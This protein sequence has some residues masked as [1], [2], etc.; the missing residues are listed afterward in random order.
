M[1]A[2][3]PPPAIYDILNSPGTAAEI[4]TFLRVVRRHAP[5][6]LEPGALWLEPACGT[7]R[8]LRALARRG[9]RTAGFDT[10]PCMLAY[11]AG[12]RELREAVLFRADMGDFAGPAAAAGLLDGSAAAALNPV[13]SLRHLD[14][15]RAVLD[16]LEHMAGLLEPGGAYLVGISLT[17][18][19]RLE[20]EED[21]WEG[22]RSRCRVSQLVNYLPPEPGTSRARTETVISHLTVTRPRGAEH[23]DHTYGLRTYDEDQW[24][25]LVSRSPLR[26]AGSYDA[27][28]RP[29]GGRTLPYQLEVLAR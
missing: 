22:A 21:L 5:G 20:P 11:A 7:G 13:N 24:N 12:R 26:R 18:Y 23:F 10:D 15:D 6:A 1:N 2:A 29:L 16:H 28:G 17:D 3:Y 4:A 19:R 14:S 27:F 9:F 25:D 8:Y